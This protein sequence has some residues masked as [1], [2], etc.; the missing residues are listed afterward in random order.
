MSRIQLTKLGD[1]FIKCRLTLTTTSVTE[2]SRTVMNKNVN[3]PPTTAVWNKRKYLTLWKALW[4]FIPLDFNQDLY[5][6]FLTKFYIFHF[7]YCFQIFFLQNVRWEYIMM[8][9]FFCNFYNEY[10][11]T[12]IKFH[13]PQRIN[14]PSYKCL[15]PICDEFK[16]YIFSANK[17]FK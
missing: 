17:F 1:L 3:F 5:K 16:I 7:G 15:G 11:I 9:W 4:Y 12:E 13:V 6:N 14:Y 2:N 8:L 10:I